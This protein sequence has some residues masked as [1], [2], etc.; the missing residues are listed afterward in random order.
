MKT[1]PHAPTPHT[2][3][4]RLARAARHI[5]FGSIL[6][7]AVLLVAT[8]SACSTMWGYGPVNVIP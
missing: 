2:E 8:Y 7:A 3:A 4:V 1:L 5:P 6:L